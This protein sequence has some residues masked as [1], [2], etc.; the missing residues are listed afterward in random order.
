MFGASVV[1]SLP[2]ILEQHHT[3]RLNQWRP[4]KEDHC[5]QENTRPQEIRE[6]TLADVG[7][8][9]PAEVIQNGPRLICS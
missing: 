7:M 6:A 5:R 9:R 3:F 8:S 4:L 1:A 2:A